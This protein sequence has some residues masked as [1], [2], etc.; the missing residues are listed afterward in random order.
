MDS[1]VGNMSAAGINLHG[2]QL[3][4]PDLEEQVLCVLVIV[5]PH[6]AQRSLKWFSP[7]SHGV[8]KNQD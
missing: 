2:Q 5:F 3:L 4:H 6:Q 8:I 1:N 7:T